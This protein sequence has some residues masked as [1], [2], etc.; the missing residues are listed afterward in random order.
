M[1]LGVDSYHPTCVTPSLC[2]L[3]G[4][5]EGIRQHHTGKPWP[6]DLLQVVLRE[7]VRPQRLRLRTGGRNTQH[8]PRRAA[9]N[10]TWTVSLPCGWTLSVSQV[11]IQYLYMYWMKSLW[12]WRRVP[13]HEYDAHMVYKV[14]H[15]GGQHDTVWRSIINIFTSH[16]HNTSLL[17]MSFVSCVVPL[18]S[19]AVMCSNL[20]TFNSRSSLVL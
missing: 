6:G 8:G 17:C 18:A 19:S 16:H 20:D 13:A 11:C 12:W 10:Q 2:V 5:Q 4:L 9:W 7:E 1:C 3:S 15:Q 14:L